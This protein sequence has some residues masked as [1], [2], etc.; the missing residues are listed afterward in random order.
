[1][2][3][4]FP[5]QA[6][7]HL[8]QSIE[9]QQE[10][11]LQAANQEVRRIARLIEQL[12][13]SIRECRQQS[14]RDVEAGTSAAGIRFALEVESSLNAKRQ[15]LELELL[16]VTRIR[17]QQQQAFHKARL[18]RE[19]FETLRTAQF[20]EYRRHQERRDQK[21]LDELFLLQ[22]AFRQRG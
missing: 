9:H 19:T 14:A 16:R 8:L 17:D 4:R 13:S 3:F 11:R 1:M 12:D 22:Q 5:L 10:I 2:S 20:R 6:V 18:E 21:L 15:N 7:L